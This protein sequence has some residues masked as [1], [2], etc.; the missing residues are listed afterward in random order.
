MTNYTNIIYV[1]NM[2]ENIFLRKYILIL[3]IYTKL[4]TIET[5]NVLLI[6]YSKTINFDFY[7]QIDDTKS[8]E[9]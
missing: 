8:F 9:N 7:H 3:K 6:L 5:F 2:R 1:K 4:E